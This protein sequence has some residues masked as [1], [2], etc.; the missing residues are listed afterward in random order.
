MSGQN[1]KDSKINRVI[2]RQLVINDELVKVFALLRLNHETDTATI[3]LLTD[4][5]ERL[6]NSLALATE[7]AHRLEAQ[8]ERLR[9][10]LGSAL[11]ARRQREM[12]IPT[13]E[14]RWGGR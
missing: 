2:S 8:N 1:T 4:T 11:F 9:K 14:P 13:L 5:A 10:Y 7:T 6:S 12:Q 3:K